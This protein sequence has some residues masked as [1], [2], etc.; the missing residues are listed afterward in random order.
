M[1]EIT[2]KKSSPC[3]F[4]SSNDK[5]LSRRQKFGQHRHTYYDGETFQHWG[6]ETNLLKMSKLG[7]LRWNAIGVVIAR[8]PFGMFPK[9]IQVQSDGAIKS[10]CSVALEIGRSDRLRSLI[11]TGVPGFL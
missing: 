1:K 3:L 4:L 7:T 8:E 9:E 10:V 11:L 5:K 2:S 6:W